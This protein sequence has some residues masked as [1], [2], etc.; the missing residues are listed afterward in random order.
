MKTI[1]NLIVN[2]K[3]FFELRV[4]YQKIRKDIFKNLSTEE[5]LE[6][7]LGTTQKNLKNFRK[8]NLEIF[9]IKFL[10]IVTKLQ[11]VLIP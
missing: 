7:N 11:F 5:I 6:T 3:H 10:K 1:R 4:F 8:N 9:F 2:L